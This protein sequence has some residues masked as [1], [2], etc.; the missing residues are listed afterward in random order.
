[1]DKTFKFYSEALDYVIEN[2]NFWANYFL[3]P[4]SFDNPLPEFTMDVDVCCGV[5]RCAL[6]SDSMDEV[7]KFDFG[8]AF[9]QNELDIYRAAKE[10]HLD[11]CFAAVR[12]LGTYIKNVRI[13]VI[14]D[15]PYFMDE[16]SVS[17]SVEDKILEEGKM[18]DCTICLPLYAYE[19]VSHYYYGSTTVTD[20]DKAFCGHN[21][22]LVERSREVGAAIRHCW[23]DE[24]YW[25]LS[26]FCNEWDINDLHTGN[27]G[28]R[29]KD[30]VIM[31]YAGWHDEF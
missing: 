11:E 27:V 7:V 29:G 9:C 24:V 31:D 4:Y 8:G 26:D 6:V 22:P 17:D 15:L 14:C 2:S 3:S 19:K 1:M 12:Y 10:Q 30:F 25:E 13:P 28:W 21:S 16:L 18:Q 20:D 5:S 23:G